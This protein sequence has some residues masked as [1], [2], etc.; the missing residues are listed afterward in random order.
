MHRG[1]GEPTMQLGSKRLSLLDDE[2]EASYAYRRPWRLLEL[3]T[4]TTPIHTHIRV[5]QWRWLSTPLE[6]V[7]RDELNR[8]N[9][10]LAYW[11]TEYLIGD[12]G[13]QLHR[14]HMAVARRPLV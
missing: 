12:H 6:W 14:R 1:S 7:A 10:D 5:P 2:L 3:R 9:D 8:M 11:I 13:G 4:A